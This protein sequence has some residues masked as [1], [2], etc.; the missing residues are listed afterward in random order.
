MSINT[1]MLNGVHFRTPN[2][3]DKYDDPWDNLMYAILYQAMCDCR[4]HY[5]NDKHTFVE[6][7]NNALQWLDTTGR[8]Y[9]EYLKH[10]PRK[11][12]TES[13]ERKRKFYA[14]KRSHKTGKFDNLF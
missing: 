14:K 1:K 10:R 6:G 9:Y 12:I 8:E 2:K 7:E 3:F 4:K 5:D 13:T 11:R